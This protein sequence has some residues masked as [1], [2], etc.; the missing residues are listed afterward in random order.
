MSRIPELDL[1]FVRSQFPAF[2]EPSL[3]GWAFFE[4]AGGSYAARQTISRLHEYYTRTKVQPYA[5]YPAAAEAG[6]LMDDAYVRLGGLLNVGE[7]EVLLAFEQEHD[8]LEKAAFNEVTIDV[9]LI[10]IIIIIINT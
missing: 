4:N 8:L 10:I 6:R 5:P 7:D 1:G 2:D 9:L 3:N